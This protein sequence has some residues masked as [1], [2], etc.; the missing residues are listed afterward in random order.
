VIKLSFLSFFSSKPPE[1]EVYTYEQRLKKLEIRIQL[2]ESEIL[3]LSV[4]QDGLRNKVLRKIQKTQ[5]K[6]EEEE[7]PKDLYSGILLPDR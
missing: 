2:V 6:E 5:F 1:K 7:K 3:A 4:A